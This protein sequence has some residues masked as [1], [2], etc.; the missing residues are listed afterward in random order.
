MLKILKINVPVTLKADPD[1][2]D[3]LRERL[4]E[5]LQIGIEGGDLDFDVMDEESEE[6]EMEE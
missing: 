1:D 5:H 3:D 2:Q 4:F 6:V